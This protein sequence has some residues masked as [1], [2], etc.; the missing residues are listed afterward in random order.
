MPDERTISVY[1]SEAARYETLTETD[2]QR[3]ALDWFLAA[4]PEK[5]HI[6][7]LGCGPGLHATEMV[8]RGHTVSAL[9][10]TPEFVDAARSRGIDARLGT[11][12]DLTEESAYD[13]IWASF[14]L[15]HAP[16]ADMPRHLAA[17]HRALCPGGHLY[18]GL[19]LG[20]GEHRDD[21]GRFYTY[22]SEPELTGL[23]DAAGFTVIETKTGTGKGLSGSEDPFILILSHA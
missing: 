21:L 8:A 5:A 6:F 12:D 2:I 1:S 11:F 20:E 13:G 18:L 16:H 15:L 7:D 19:K 9:D 23:L 10:A 4:L 14:S 22:Y 3:R 17:I